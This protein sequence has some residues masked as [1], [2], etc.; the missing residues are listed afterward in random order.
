MTGSSTERR[1]RGI[2]ESMSPKD[3]A[4]LHIREAIERYG[5]L[6]DYLKDHSWADPP[7]ERLRTE[8]REAAQ[9]LLKDTGTAP[10]SVTGAIRTAQRDADFLMMLAFA[11]N[12]ALLENRRSFDLQTG[13]LLEHI[14]SLQEQ[15][16][17]GIDASSMLYDLM[18]LPYPL[19]NDIA[20]SAEANVSRTV[21]DNEFPTDEIESG[22]LPTPSA[23]EDAAGTPAGNMQRM[24][25]NCV[26]VRGETKQEWDSGTLSPEWV[27]WLMGFPEGWLD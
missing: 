11:C 27:E 17:I 15:E 16:L 13:L 21:I 9:A 4:L 5:S 1:L 20:A 22:L 14:I 12:F 2:R 10:A 26:E 24:L 25:G 8:V 18:F 23:N 6:G 19:D 3:L 7:R